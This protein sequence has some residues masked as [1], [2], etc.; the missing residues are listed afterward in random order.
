M[1][2]STIFGSSILPPANGHG[3]AGAVRYPM[4]RTSPEYTARWVRLL[5]ETSLEADMAPP[6]G[7]IATATSGSLGE[8]ATIPPALSVRS[9][10]YGSKV[11]RLHRLLLLRER[12]PRRSR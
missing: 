5:P 11:H 6:V 9:T 7:P 2:I 8:W 1:A 4:V 3:W 12:T 10:T